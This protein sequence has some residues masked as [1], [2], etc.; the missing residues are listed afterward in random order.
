MT[1]TLTDYDYMTWPYDWA[2]DCDSTKTFQETKET[3][4]SDNNIN[5]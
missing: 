2:Y 1:M 3:V 4:R 5:N